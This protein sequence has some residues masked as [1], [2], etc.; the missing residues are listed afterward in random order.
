MVLVSY[1]A[2]EGRKEGGWRE[3]WW[4]RVESGNGTAII[5]EN[6]SVTGSEIKRAGIGVAKENGGDCRALVEVEPFFGLLV[7]PMR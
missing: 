5:G 7:S 6:G 2:F 1:F 4:R 3:D